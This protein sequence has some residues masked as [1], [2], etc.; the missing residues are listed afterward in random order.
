[1]PFYLHIRNCLQTL[2]P[3]PI[4]GGT[5]DVISIGH[6][7]TLYSFCAAKE[8][9]HSRHFNVTFEA[10]VLQSLAGWEYFLYVFG[11]FE[12]KLGMKLIT[13]EN[14]KVVTVSSMQK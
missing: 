7:K 3:F 9:K 11:V 5:F 4:A 13:C 2:Q 12:G 10:K 1:M 14:K 6:I 8:G